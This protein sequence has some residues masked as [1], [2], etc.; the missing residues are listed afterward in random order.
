VFFH[1][2]L[3]LS[4]GHADHLFLV[5]PHRNLFA[6]S[7]LLLGWLSVVHNSK[8]Y[9]GAFK[10]ADIIGSISAHESKVTLQ[11]EHANDYA[12]LCGRRSREHVNVSNCWRSIREM[13]NFLQDVTVNAKHVISRELVDIQRR[14]RSCDLVVI[15]VRPSK[16]AL[17]KYLACEE[18]RSTAKGKFLTDEC[19]CQSVI[20]CDHFHLVRRIF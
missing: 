12:F 7:L 15:D 14:V 8:S 2:F 3:L 16:F 5:R 6:F 4:R 17:A 9:V 13:N 18:R 10:G 20:T 11:V 19:S 1:E